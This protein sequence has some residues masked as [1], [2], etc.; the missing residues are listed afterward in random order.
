M[1]PPPKEELER[2]YK[3]GLPYTALVFKYG[4]TY[5]TITMWMK[6]YG[7]PPRPPGYQKKWKY[8]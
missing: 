3:K 1:N 7:I 6:M 5:K 8:I 4:V 2:L